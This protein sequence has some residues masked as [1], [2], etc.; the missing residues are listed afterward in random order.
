MIAVGAYWTITYHVLYMAYIYFTQSS[1]SMSRF[2]SS[3][4]DRVITPSSNKA[5]NSLSLSAA[6]LVSAT[7]EGSSLEKG[8]NQFV[9]EH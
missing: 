8:M 5:F 2:F 4:S 7:T 9:H 6:E 3:N 1:E